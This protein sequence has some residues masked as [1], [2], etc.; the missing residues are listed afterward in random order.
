MNF[1]DI[2]EDITYVMTIYNDP[3][4]LNDNPDLKCC[5]MDA[6][7]VVSKFHLDNRQAN[8]PVGEHLDTLCGHLNSIV[9]EARENIYMFEDG[10]TD[11][12]CDELVPG[13]DSLYLSSDLMVNALNGIMPGLIANSTTLTYTNMGTDE[14]Q[15]VILRALKPL[16]TDAFIIALKTPLSARLNIPTACYF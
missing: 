13:V 3:D 7:Y 4:N 8:C 2:K 1:T 11:R 10:F 5:Y 16:M 6:V 9:T 15:Q 14:H 12:H